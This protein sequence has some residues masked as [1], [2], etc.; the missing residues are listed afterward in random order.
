MGKSPT[1]GYLTTELSSRN[2][3]GRYSRSLV[4]AIGD[5][6]TVRVLTM[7]GAPNETTITDVRCVL[8]LANFHPFAQ[9]LIAWQTFRAFRHC[10]IIHVL[11]EPYAPGAVLVAQLLR[12][13]ITMTMHGTYSLPPVHFSTKKLMMKYMYQHLTR[14]TTGSLYTEKKVREIVSIGVCEFIPNGVNLEKFYQIPSIPKEERILTVGALKPRKGVDIVIRALAILKDEFPHLQYSVIGD[15]D[16]G[17]FFQEL[18]QLV[19]DLD[20]KER[21]EFINYIK[22]EDLVKLYNRS[23]IFV[24]AARDSEGSFEGFPMVFYEA[25]A[26]GTPIISTKGFGSEYAIKNGKNGFVVEPDNPQAIADAIRMLL[27]DKEQY[28]F[29][30]KGA[31]HEAAEHTWEKV[32]IKLEAFYKR[33][34]NQQSL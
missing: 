22:D 12:I 14:T 5:T 29:M 4:E 3:W 20:I 13:P 7:R 6:A 23:K 9:L 21:V 33:A 30:Q 28:T 8:P 17:A 32:A 11:V 25:N 27:I 10:D 16:R 18:Q 15:D 26:C 31:L 1:I 34:I 19:G 2:G 24:L